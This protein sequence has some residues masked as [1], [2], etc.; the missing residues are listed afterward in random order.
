M[1][2]CLEAVGVVLVSYLTLTFLFPQR[3]GWVWWP[4]LSPWKPW[5]SSTVAVFLIEKLIILSISSFPYY[6]NFLWFA[7][8][9]GLERITSWSNNYFNYI[10]L[11]FFFCCTV[12]K[13]D[14]DTKHQVGSVC[15]RIE[16][17]LKTSTLADLHTSFGT[18]KD[19][20]KEK[21]EKPALFTPKAFQQQQSA[22][23]R[24][25]NRVSPSFQSKA[26]RAV[27]FLLFWFSS[28]AHFFFFICYHKTCN[29][30]GK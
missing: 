27:F 1:N 23:K 19:N 2:F 6:S 26:L 8:N 15:Y 16:T 5:A 10:V 14:V 11:L 13:G 17:L 25:T 4:S 12:R 28:F 7:T 24:N 20:E 3:L 22:A 21:P 9:D 29:R 18:S 30:E